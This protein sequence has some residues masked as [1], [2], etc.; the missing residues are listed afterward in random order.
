MK[1]IEITEKYFSLNPGVEYI[2][3]AY[4]FPETELGISFSVIHKENLTTYYKSMVSELHSNK[5]VLMI[6]F[7]LNGARPNILIMGNIMPLQDVTADKL[8]H[9]TLGIQHSGIDMGHTAIRWI[10]T[11]IKEFAKIQ[12]FDIKRIT[13]ATRYTGARA[14]NNP[15]VDGVTR[16]FSID[17]PA[18]E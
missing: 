14:K 18:T 2:L 12:G 11:K 6:Y 7:E 10:Y 4:T 1:L 3:E 5:N 13:S 15:G 9:T 8:V 16:S 17:T